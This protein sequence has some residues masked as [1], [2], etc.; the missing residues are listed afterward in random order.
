MKKRKIAVLFGGCSTEY[1]VSLQSAYSIIKSM[2]EELYDKIL[3]GITREGEWYRFRGDLKKIK[4]DTWSMDDSCIPAVI[5]PSRKLHGVI[6]FYPSRTEYISID[7]AFPVLHGKNGEDGTVQG[8]LKLAGIPIV[9]CEV[10]SSAVCMDK[11]IAHIVARSAGIKTPA[12]VVIKKD[13]SDKEIE[14]LSEVIGFPLF[15]KPANAGS[16]FGITKVVKREE[17]IKA[18]EEAFSHD[19]K[20]ILEENIDG[21]EVGCAVLGKDDKL[22]IGEV[23]EI[24]LTNGFFDY[25]EKYNLVT[26]KIHMPARISEEA[27][28]KIKNTALSLYSALCCTGFARVDMFLTAE[29]DIVFNEINTIPGFTDHSR[30]PNMMK[31]IGMSFEEIIDKLIDEAV[32]A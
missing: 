10:L 16:S 3:I 7:G 20:V 23:D 21:F 14:E 28:A 17:L 15:V 24:E 12:S 31:G 30:Y 1:E 32:P 19:D 22:I 26:S 11:D 2:K 29:G 8:L 6:E 13:K 4:E 27:A 9:G 18:V 5:S 25:T